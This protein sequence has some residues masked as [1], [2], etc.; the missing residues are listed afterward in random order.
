VEVVEACARH[1]AAGKLGWLLT[2]CGR[3]PEAVAVLE[4][5]AAARSGLH[6]PKGELPPPPGALFSQPQSHV[7]AGPILLVARRSLTSPPVCRW[8]SRRGRF[9]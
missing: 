4:E 6:P 2:M 7:P 9:C 1:R 5:S 3:N 8:P